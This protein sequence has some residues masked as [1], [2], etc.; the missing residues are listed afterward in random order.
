MMYRRRSLSLFAAALL[1]GASLAAA[2]PTQQQY[3][4]TLRQ[5]QQSQDRKNQL[6]DENAKLTEEIARLKTQLD[7]I[8]TRVRE[9]EASERTYFLRAHYAAWQTFIERY[10]PLLKR[11]RSYLNESSSNRP[12]DASLAPGEW[13][14]A[15]VTFFDADWPFSATTTQPATD[16]AA[17]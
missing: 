2:Q 3:D 4:D 9:L 12:L 1:A 10:P 7:L 14:A 11:F 17:P 16:T 8:S 5:L 13:I 15:P 6:A